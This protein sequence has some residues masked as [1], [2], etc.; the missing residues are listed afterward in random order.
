MNDTTRP[1]HF[2]GMA[3]LHGYLPQ[4]CDVYDTYDDAVDSLADL[5]ELGKR[6][7]AELRRDGFLEL[8]IRRDG[9]EYCEITECD[10]D[11]PECHS[12]SM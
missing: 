7:R 8:N 12:D 11:D 9:N 2:I 10:C 4:T 6:R 1:V 3:G 5:H